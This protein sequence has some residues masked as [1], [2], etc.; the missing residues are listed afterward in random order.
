MQGNSLLKLIE[1]YKIKV[2]NKCFKTMR[3]SC[4]RAKKFDVP[5][6][7]PEPQLNNFINKGLKN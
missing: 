2:I 7:D 3:T 5:L 4:T 1:F 6:F